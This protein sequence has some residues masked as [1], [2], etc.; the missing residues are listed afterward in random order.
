[1]TETIVNPLPPEGC[2]IG[3]VGKGGDGKSTIAGHMLGHWSAWGIPCA[4]MDADVPGES[5][6]G[7]LFEWSD[8]HDLGASVHRAPAASG[9]LREITSITPK[10]GIG[11]MDSGAWMRHRGN[12]C[13]A[14]LAASE[15]LVVTM[16]PTKAEFKRIWSIISHVEQLALTGRAPRVVVLLTRTDARTAMAE[17]FRADLEAEKQTVLKT[18]IPNQSGRDGYGQALGKPLRLAQDDAMSQLAAEL[19]REAVKKN[20]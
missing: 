1:M 3:I 18:T 11:L 12:G 17:E 13:L 4:G 5:E 2:R 19:L 6:D 20:G 7:S 16:Q 10:H 15:L 9:V 8:E 14:V